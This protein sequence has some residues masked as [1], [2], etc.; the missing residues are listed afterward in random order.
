[1]DTTS[2]RPRKAG[3][4]ND[5]ALARSQASGASTE[6]FEDAVRI[7]AT[8]LFRFAYWKV[9]DRA[10]AEDLVQETFARAWRSWDSLEDRNAARGWLYTILR[11]EVARNFE[12]QQPVL[13]DESELEN[14]VA[15][16]QSGVAEGVE[17]QDLLGALPETY[18]EPLLLQV[19]G[20]FSCAEIGKIL[21]LSEGA[22]MQRVSRARAA[23]REL[24]L[25][26][27][28]RKD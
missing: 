21:S 20:G 12:R 11:N 23:L 24:A 27:T 9:K 19:L 18:R 5:E 7:H 2:V 10:L 8:E 28:V 26:A 16:A 13:A 1:M 15:E 6:R 4:R 17:M 25:G 3:T 22:V 14:M